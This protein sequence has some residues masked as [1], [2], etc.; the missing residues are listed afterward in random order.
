[1][2]TY[3]R[4]VEATFPRQTTENEYSI[5]QLFLL[6]DKEKCKKFKVSS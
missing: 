3:E 4:I 5:K 1:M 6:L 2:S